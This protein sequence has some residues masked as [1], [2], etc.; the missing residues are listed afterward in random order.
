M[1]NTTTAAPEQTGTKERV[2]RRRSRFERIVTSTT[3]WRGFIAIVGFLLFWEF[4]TRFEQMFGVRFPVIGLIPPPTEVF[5][6]WTNMLDAPGYWANWV[7]SGFRVFAGFLIAMLFG[8]PFGLMLAMN[9]YFRGAFFPT[10]ELLRPIPPL[11]WVPASLIFW[12]S[13]EASIIFVI[14]LGAF[15][16]IV[17]NVLGGARSV[18]IRYLQA[19]QSMGAKPWQMFSRV[20]LPAVLPSAFIG[21]AVAMGI[22]WEVVLAAEMIAGGGESGGGLGFF[23]WSSYMGGS[24]A[25]VVV[26]MISIG[27]AGYASSALIRS[28][29]YYSMPWRRLF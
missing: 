14:F 28:V 1:S 11:A 15:Y 13:N 23:I 27:I 2:I 22:T 10:F 4:A 9:K 25:N 7:T 21:A 29:G 18:D 24:M 17:L 3:F 19:A 16:T 6:A 26:G 5:V 12:P 8:L 20:V